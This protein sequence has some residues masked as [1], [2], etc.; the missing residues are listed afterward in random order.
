[1]DFADHLR[2]IRS[3]GEALG[4]V[5]VADLSVRVPSCPDWD[6]AGLV[7]HTGWVHR[8]VTS[9]LAAPPGEKVSAR[10]VP[11][12]PAGDAVLGWY[13]EGLAALGTAPLATAVGPDLSLPNAV[14]NARRAGALDLPPLVFELLAFGLGVQRAPHR[15]S[16]PQ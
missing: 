3:E 8:W 15:R 16:P 9:I 14:G 11:V 5:A 13:A 12:A 2:T 6:V 1:M 4:A 10:D 7:G